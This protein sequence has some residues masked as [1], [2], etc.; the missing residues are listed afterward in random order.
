MTKTKPCTNGPRH[1]WTWVKNF[2]RTR[3]THTARG[4]SAQISLKGLYRCACGET[5]IGQPNHNAPDLRGSDPI[6]GVRVAGVTL[7]KG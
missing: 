1:S 7:T 6:P 4:S 5:R 3:I 2:N